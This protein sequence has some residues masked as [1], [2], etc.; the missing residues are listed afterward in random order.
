MCFLVCAGKTLW[1]NYVLRRCLGEKQ[2]V[3]WHQGKLKYFFSDAG[4]EAIESEDFPHPP[5]TW[6][7]VDSAEADRLPTSIYHKLHKLFPIYVTSPSEERWSKLHQLRLPR[8]IIMNPWT[9]A[10]LSKA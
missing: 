1:I 7:L 5:Y 3:I 2:P 8:L 6:C 4:V 10:E 9:K